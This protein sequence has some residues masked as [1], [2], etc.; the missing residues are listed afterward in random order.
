MLT[1]NILVRATPASLM[2]CPPTSAST[3]RTRRA[4]TVPPG[5]AMEPRMV[6][7]ARKMETVERRSVRKW[8]ERPLGGQLGQGEE[9]EEEGAVS[10]VLTVLGEGLAR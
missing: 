9:G 10:T 5:A 2:I 8:A 4:K 6:Q 3:M 1:L 7:A